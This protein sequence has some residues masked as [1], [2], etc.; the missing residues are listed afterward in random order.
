M[1][2]SHANWVRKAK[3][4]GWLQLFAEAL[5]ASQKNIDKEIQE[6]VNKNFYDWL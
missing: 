2:K 3:G 4:I 1:K 5:I 6:A